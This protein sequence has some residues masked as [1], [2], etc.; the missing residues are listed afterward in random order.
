V[1]VRRIH[2]GRIGPNTAELVGFRPCL[3]GAGLVANGKQGDTTIALCPSIGPTAGNLVAGRVTYIGR[4]TQ[5]TAVMAGFRPSL[6]GAG[7][8]VANGKQGDTSIPLRSSIGPGAGNLVA[9]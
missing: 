7:L 5:T 3:K 6:K 1:A 2:I 8:A 4:I 9:G